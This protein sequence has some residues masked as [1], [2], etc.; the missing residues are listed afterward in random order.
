MV[1]QAAAR[2]P[3]DTSWT[4]DIPDSF[5]ARSRM[6]ANEG[7]IRFRAVRLRLASPALSDFLCYQE[8]YIP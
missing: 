1:T 7:A 4:S 5:S 3:I 6:V 8:L 2:R